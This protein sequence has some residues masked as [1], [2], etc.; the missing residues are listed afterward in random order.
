MRPTALLI[1]SFMVLVVTTAH[2]RDYKAGSLDIAD[3]WSRATPK[4]ASVAA[5]YMRI[6][7][8]GTAPDRLISGSSDVA[9]TS[10][11]MR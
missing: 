9:P 11:F 10:K 8:T 1:A 4:A 3:P 6:T 5:G 2:A 7:N